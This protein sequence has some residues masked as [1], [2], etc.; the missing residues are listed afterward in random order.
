MTMSQM[1]YAVLRSA[2]IGN[3]AYSSKL[4]RVDVHFHRSRFDDYLPGRYVS[5]YYCT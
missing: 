1:A 5:I 3:T 4:Q 2:L